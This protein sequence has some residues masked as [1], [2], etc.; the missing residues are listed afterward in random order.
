MNL[1]VVEE[2][3]IELGGRVHCSIICEMC[4]GL[5]QE[6]PVLFHG[7]FL[8]LCIAK[9]NVMAVYHLYSTDNMHSCLLPPV[10][11]SS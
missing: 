9:F 4:C 2:V 6:F 8:V 11:L 5:Y 10:R 1:L 3:N 7:A